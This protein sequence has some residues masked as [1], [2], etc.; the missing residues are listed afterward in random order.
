MVFIEDFFKVGQM[1]GRTHAFGGTPREELPCGVVVDQLVVFVTLYV[2]DKD[3][4]PGM[5]TDPGRH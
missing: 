1:S 3:G 2:R 4:N 5:M